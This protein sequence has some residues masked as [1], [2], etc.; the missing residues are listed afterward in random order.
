MMIDVSVSACELRTGPECGRWF[1]GMACETESCFQ[2]L[3]S[4]YRPVVLNRYETPEGQRSGDS[5][6]HQQPADCGR[7]LSSCASERYGGGT[8]TIPDTDVGDFILDA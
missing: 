8:I 5:E 2:F 1:A 7:C 4:V 6:E 3:E